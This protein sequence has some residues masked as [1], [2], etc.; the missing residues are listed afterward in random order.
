MID[1]PDLPECLPADLE[2]RMGRMRPERKERMLQGLYLMTYTG[3]ALGMELRSLMEAN[4]FLMPRNSSVQRAFLA[5][6]PASGLVHKDTFPFIRRSRAALLRL[7]DAGKAVCQEMGW[8]LAENEWE[9]LIRGHRGQALP[10][11][12]IGLLAF[13]YQ[14]RLRGWKTQLLPQVKAGVRPD[15]RVQK[16]SSD[17]LYVEFETDT[18]DKLDKW[19]NMY[20][21]QRLVAIVTFVESQRKRFADECREVNASVIATDIDTLTRQAHAGEPGRLWRTH[22]RHWDDDENRVRAWLDV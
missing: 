5:D 2:R 18:R 11:H 3:Y 4:L 1:L 14:A 7:T 13:C 19:K 9:T 22:W 15:V 12:T 8:N 10:R 21:F 6:L 16:G 17:P 20:E